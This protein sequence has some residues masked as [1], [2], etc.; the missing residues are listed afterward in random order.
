MNGNR[1]L[2]VILVLQALVL[3]TLWT[4]GPSLPQA[5]AQVPDPGAQRLQIIEQLRQLNGKM[6]RLVEILQ[7]GNLQVKVAT[8]DEQKEADRRNAR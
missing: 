4:G 3:L 7:S 8:D 6:D 5:Q 2:A 1:I